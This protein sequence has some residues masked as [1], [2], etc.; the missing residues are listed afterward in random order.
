MKKFPIVRA[1][2]TYYE[3]GRAVGEV[4]RE[5]IVTLFEKNRNIK[6]RGVLFGYRKQSKTPESI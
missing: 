5:S 4:M 1:S 2:G 3:V 6:S